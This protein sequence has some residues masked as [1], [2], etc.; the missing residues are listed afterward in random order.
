[1]DTDRNANGKRAILVPLD[2]TA[3]SRTVCGPVR[4]LFAPDRFRI[5]ILHIASPPTGVG[6][7]YRPAA[8]GPDYTLYSYD[9]TGGGIDDGRRASY[10]RHALYQGHAHEEYRKRLQRELERELTLFRDEGYRASATVHFGDPVAEIVAFARDRSVAAVAM[11]THGRSGLG[12]ALQGSV[13]QD[14]FARLDRAVPVMLFRP[15]TRT[16]A[17]TQ[18]GRPS[19]R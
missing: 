5:A 1:M 10:Q 16:D 2:G 13:A 3:F 11:A 17:P 7:P 6:G 9:L 14:V 8:V 12:R 18:S 19:S 15:R 4:D